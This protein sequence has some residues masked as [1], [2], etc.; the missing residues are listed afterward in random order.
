[1][2]P[3]QADK[4]KR[5]LRNNKGAALLMALF[6]V[7]LIIFIAIEVSYDTAVEYRVATADYQRVKAYYA[8]KAGVELS[9][10]RIQLYQNVYE[11]YKDQLKGQTQ[12]LDL[13][14]Q[15]PFM[16][17]PTVGKDVGH[18]SAEEI[19][20]T[21]KESLMDA[22]YITQIESEGGKID[23]NDLASPS[24]ALRLSTRKQLKQLIENRLSADDDWADE[25]RNLNTEELINNIQ[26]WIDEDTVGLNGG[27]ESGNYPDAKSNFV[28]PN[29]GFKTLEELHMVKGMTDALYQ[30]LAPQVTVYGLKGI[31]VNYADKKVLMSIDPQITEEIADE[32]VARRGN[33]ELGP[34]KD[35]NDFKSL[36][37]TKGVNVDKFNESQIPLY[38]DAEYNFRIKSIGQFGNSSREI[39]AIVYDFDTV[40]ERLE[41]LLSTTTTSLDP[42][43]TTGGGTS[44]G[45]A[46]SGSTTSTTLQPKK[47][48]GRPSV[49]YW[50]E[51]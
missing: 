24:E 43:S 33:P 38:F 18:V 41:K 2:H 26:D 50:H 27:S 49:I 14:W 35:E 23:L 13:I 1:M 8:A 37:S 19:K 9:L 21:V 47:A 42:G 22:T 5:V 30:A 12:L 34:F 4:I 3:K 7:T 6:T 40:K 46:P 48:A 31:N 17:P 10:L 44:G 45:T 15:F 32:C 36:L 28:P 20:D 51:D 39:I 25:N 11:Q 29:Q 16:W